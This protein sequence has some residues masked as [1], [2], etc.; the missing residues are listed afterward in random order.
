MNTKYT[1]QTQKNQVLD[2]KSQ[3]VNKSCDS[4]EL[5]RF[6]NNPKLYIS[7][8]EGCKK[9]FLKYLLNFKNAKWVKLRNITIQQG[10]KKLT[11]KEY[12]IRQIQRISKHYESLGFYNKSQVT[13]FSS[14]NYSFDNRL[15]EGKLSFSVWKETLNGKAKKMHLE[16]GVVM[17]DVIRNGVNLNNNI[18]IN[19]K[20]N[21]LLPPT[22]KGIKKHVI[23]K[24]YWLKKKRATTLK[25]AYRKFII[26]NKDKA[27]I[28]D[29]L[30]DENIKKQIV[31]PLMDEI[32]TGLGLTNAEKLKLVAYP[33]EALVYAFEKTLY[34]IKTKKPIISKMGFLIALC[35]EFCTKNKLET[36]WKW[37]FVICDILNIQTSPGGGDLAIS[38]PPENSTISAGKIMSDNG[39]SDKLQLNSV[40]NLPSYSISNITKNSNSSQQFKEKGRIHKGEG[41]NYSFNFETPPTV[42][43]INDIQAKLN[44]YKKYLQLAQ[45]SYKMQPNA[46]NLKHVEQYKREIEF[47]S[48]KLMH[49]NNAV[50]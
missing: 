9:D 48:A 49:M 31:T 43:E 39:Y 24:K 8:L 10:I 35:N 12:S 17:S 20:Y 16:I 33:K 41:V 40:K 34:M 25:Q 22:P 27:E 26:A 3:Q 45:E 28:K 38:P 5:T 30:K 36:D 23:S 37:Y 46:N 42:Q 15:K 14:N 18:L 29:L 7:K 21:M 50:S 32:A 47:L 44:R 13:K 11:K 6:L 1:N 19:N 4:I 2:N